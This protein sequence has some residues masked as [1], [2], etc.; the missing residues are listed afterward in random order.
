MISLVALTKYRAYEHKK[1]VRARSYAG[2]EEA[3]D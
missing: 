1:Q 2:R 3:G